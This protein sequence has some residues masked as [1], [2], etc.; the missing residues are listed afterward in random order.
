VAI[1]TLFP[2][3]EPVVDLEARIIEPAIRGWPSSSGTLHLRNPQ[4]FFGPSWKP[5]ALPIERNQDGIRATLY[6]LSVTNRY[7]TNSAGS[8]LKL[9]RT[10]IRF[11][12]TDSLNHP[13]RVIGCELS[14]PGGNRL[15]VPI[16]KVLE[17]DRAH[18]FSDALFD[19]EPAWRLRVEAE[20]PANDP[21]TTVDRV[22]FSGIAEPPDDDETGSRRPSPPPMKGCPSIP[23]MELSLYQFSA[24]TA[25]KV[26]LGVRGSPPGIRVELERVVDETGRIWNAKEIGSSSMGARGTDGFHSYVMSQTSAPG[27]AAKSLSFVFRIQRTA[28]FEFHPPARFVSAE[29]DLR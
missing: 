11:E 23:G 27:A 26:Q 9:P 22:E 21:S 15:R 28:I 19:D 12:A 25:P 8:R 3:R 1:L 20:R 5:D 17:K 7:V 4:P 14:D 18:P 29:P 16:G 24:G 13:L 2:R 6:D 10:W